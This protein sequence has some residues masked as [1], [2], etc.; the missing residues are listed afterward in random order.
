[1]KVS[2]SRDPSLFVVTASNPQAIENLEKSV[3]S[4]VPTFL[5]QRHVPHARLSAGETYVWGLMS[6]P[7]NVR[8]W[9]A[10]QPGDLVLG[11]SYNTFIF[12]ATVVDVAR[13]SELAR[14]LWGSLQGATWELLCMLS[15]P[16]SLWLDVGATQAWLPRKFQ[17]FTRI[18]EEKLDEIVAQ[19]GSLDRFATELHTMDTCLHETTYQDVALAIAAYR[20]QPRPP[21]RRAGAYELEHEGR[22]YPVKAVFALVVKLRMGYAPQVD[23]IVTGQG[24]P[25]FRLLR[26]LGFVLRRAPGG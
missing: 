7:Q 4:P 24:T 25:A 19:F 18:S 22:W 23:E 17:G 12:A 6:G 20:E 9:E 21:V 13:S 10:M 15:K 5:V 16:T 26:R 8:N 3:C 14:E 1:M 11:V 2:F